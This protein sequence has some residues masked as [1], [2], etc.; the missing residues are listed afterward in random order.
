MHLNLWGAGL[1]DVGIVQQMPKLQVASLSVNKIASLQP[2]ASCTSLRELYMRKNQVRLFAHECP[3][4]QM[5]KVTMQ[6]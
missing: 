2:F 4:S 5:A 3:C 1:S 6:K